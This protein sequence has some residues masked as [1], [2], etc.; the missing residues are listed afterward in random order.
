MKEIVTLKGRHED[1]LEEFQVNITKV[2]RENKNKIEAE[3]KKA[4]RECEEI[5]SEARNNQESFFDRSRFKDILVY[6]NLSITPILL[7][8]LSYVLFIKK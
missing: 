5:I 3:T 1:I 8:I 7:I 6:I 2:F 4:I